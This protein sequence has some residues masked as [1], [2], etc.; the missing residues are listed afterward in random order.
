MQNIF[1]TVVIIPYTFQFFKGFFKSFPKML[2]ETPA[3][4][5]GIDNNKGYLLPGYDADIV[6]FDEG[7]NIKSVF[8]GGKKV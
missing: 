7:I 1:T 5:V 8:V 3:K 2:T 6:V 4:M